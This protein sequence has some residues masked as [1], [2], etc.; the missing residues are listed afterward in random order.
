MQILLL[1]SALDA[2][3]A[4][5]RG[6]TSKCRYSICDECQHRKS[7]RIEAR[8]V[9]SNIIWLHTVEIVYPIDLARREH[10]I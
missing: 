7:R 6:K 2:T 5:T 9:V 1:Y 3:Y 4:H 8:G 10:K